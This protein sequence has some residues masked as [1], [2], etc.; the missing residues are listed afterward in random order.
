MANEKKRS[1]TSVAN[2]LS[3]LSFF[4]PPESA[5]FAGTANAAAARSGLIAQNYHGQLNGY[6]KALTANKIKANANL[7]GRLSADPTYDGSRNKAVLLARQYEKADIDMGGRGSGNWTS[8]D[9]KKIRG[10]TWDEVSKREKLLWVEGSEGHHINNVA[11][12]PE[13]QADPDNIQFYRTKK[14]HMAL[15][16]K[17]SFQNKTSGELI[18]RNQMLRHTNRRRVFQNELRGL[19]MCAAVGFG[20]GFALSL[21]A[22]LA[23]KGVS[24]KSFAD[25][26]VQSIGVGI[27]S[28]IFYS[29]SYVVGKPI[30]TGL[31]RVGIGIDSLLSYAG[32]GLSIVAFGCLIHYL[33]LRFRGF[34]VSGA[35]MKT[36]KQAAFSISVLAVSCI[37]QGIYGGHAGVIVS[38]TLGLLFF[39][40]NVAQTIRQKKLLKKVRAY[41]IETH[42]K[43][44]VKACMTA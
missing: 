39:G 13:L 35:A 23:Q 10:L 1:L 16:H 17:G 29:E 9:I 22:E 43:L 2:R 4:S 34:G 25:S 11:D 24:A 42:Q 5:V 37:A 18:D 19:G 40:F 31:L 27:Q 36:G 41:A 33:T 8:E 21:V 20:V 44:A 32:V 38:T 6:L 30:Q 7:A 3:G 28:G 26:L 12:Y 15:G 14:D